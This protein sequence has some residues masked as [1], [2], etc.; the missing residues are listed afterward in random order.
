VGVDHTGIGRMATEHLIAQ[1]C[2]RIA[3]LRGPAVGIAN[4]RLNGYCSAL[5]EHGFRILQDYIVEAG[6]RSESGYDAMRGLLQT[7]IK[8]DG[9]FCYNDPVAVG[10]MKAIRQAGRKVPQ[11]IAVV[12]AGNVNYSDVLAIP[13]TTIDQDPDEIGRVASRI[14]LEQIESKK[15]VKRRLVLVPHRLVIRESTAHRRAK[16]TRLRSHAGTGDVVPKPHDNRH[17]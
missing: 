1:G 9:V 10:A 12:G 2:R 16:G 4:D 14:L 17:S 11:D 3:H 5:Q 6:F 8:I 7:T 15:P 13:L